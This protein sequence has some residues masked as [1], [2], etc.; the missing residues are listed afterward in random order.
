VR[1][2]CGGQD[3]SGRLLASARDISHDRTGGP[4]FRE[5]MAGR[6]PETPS[7]GASYAAFSDLPLLLS[8]STG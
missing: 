8:I 1:N 5:Q 7:F 3:V 6:R 2:K 4:S